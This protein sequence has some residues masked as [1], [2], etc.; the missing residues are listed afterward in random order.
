MPVM[1]IV[2]AA[3]ALGALALLVVV[4]LLV[5]RSAPEEGRSA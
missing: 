4:Y 1:E 2:C 5:A 3:I